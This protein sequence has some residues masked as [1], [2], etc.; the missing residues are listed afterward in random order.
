MLAAL[1]PGLRMHPSYRCI[2]LLLVVAFSSAANSGPDPPSRHAQSQPISLHH[3]PLCR[4]FPYH[5]APARDHNLTHL[6]IVV[7]DWA[8]HQ[9]HS[10][11]GVERG[12]IIYL[13]PDGNLRIGTPSNGDFHGVT[14]TATPRPEEVII[15][16]AHSHAFGRYYTA[17]QRKL[18]PADI[19]LG[20]RLASHPRASPRL[21][22]Y[23]IDIASGTI[24]EYPANGSCISPG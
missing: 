23:V 1:Q 13:Q 5:I 2:G 15:A 16:A 20:K 22:L 14:L 9:I 21:L 7:A 8:R 12:A 11:D 18:S 6:Q 19:T 3:P 10:N 24:S 17:D 4:R